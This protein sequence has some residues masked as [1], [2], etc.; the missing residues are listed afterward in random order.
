VESCIRFT[1]SDWLRLVN[2]RTKDQMSINLRF[3]GRVAI[4][5][6]AG[7]GLGRAHSLELARRGAK[8]LV[9]DFGGGVDG[10]GGSSAP[11]EAVVREIAA[12]GGTAMSNGADVTNEEQVAL[13]LTSVADT[14][15]RVDILINNA[16]ILRDAS[17]TKMS[18]SDFRKVVEVHLMGSVYCTQAVWPLMRAANYGRILM[19]TSSSGLYGNFGQSNY[20][21][22]KMALIGLMNVLHIEGM[23]NNI[24][25]NALGPGAATRMTAALLPKAVIDLMTPEAVS[26][27]AVFLVSEHAPSRVILNA[28][29]GGYSRTLIHETEGIVLGEADRTAENIAAQFERISDTDGQHLYL[30]GSQQVMNFINKAAASASMDPAVPEGRAV[31]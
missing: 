6:G 17:F 11:A 2:Q 16:G 5:T 31:T 22:A 8:V 13:M 24:R 3:D 10:T 18:S 4:V 21:A 28:T 26:P 1:L 14:W 19:T 27:A 25:I 23:K 7:A 30:D 15:G 9:N 29:A 12:A 20:G